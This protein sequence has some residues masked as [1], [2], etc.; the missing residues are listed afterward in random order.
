M[1]DDR[2]VQMVSTLTPFNIFQN[3][4]NVEGLWNEI[5]NQF[6]LIQHAFDI[7][8]SFN[9][10]ERLVQKRNEF[11]YI[12][13]HLITSTDIINRPYHGFRRHFDGKA[14]RIEIT[15]FVRKSDVK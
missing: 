8:Y 2:I 5:L 3:K 4:G 7:F 1:L 6:N 11:P 10:V 14:N 9:N 15:V 12:Y 13:S